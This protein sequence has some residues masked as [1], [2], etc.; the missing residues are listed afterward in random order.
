MENSCRK[1]YKLFPKKWILASR[2]SEFRRNSALIPANAGLFHYAGNCPVRYIDPD[3]KET[4]DSE[5]LT[6]EVYKTNPQLQLQFSW[7]SLQDFFESNPNGIVY[8]YDTISYSTGK[9]KNDFPVMD[10]SYIV[11]EIF[12][13]AKFFTSIGKLI[14][15]GAKNCSNFL[16]FNNAINIFGKGVSRKA[17]LFTFNML[18]IMSN[19][20]NGFMIAFRTFETMALT[21]SGQKFLTE[22][23]IYVSRLINYPANQAV[24]D[25]LHTMQD[26]ITSFGI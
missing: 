17:Q 23:G 6:E 24:F 22:V 1:K 9:S 2:Y 10:S 21:P 8:R 26:W 14:T 4:Y 25:M 13:G 12:L 18:N 16:L 3:G 7:E 20:E 15:Y 5:T 19:T 11:V